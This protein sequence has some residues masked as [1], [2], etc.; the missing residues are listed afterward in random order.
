MNSKK[1]NK[2]TEEQVYLAFYDYSE[3]GGVLDYQYF[4]DIFLPKYLKITS[5]K[6]EEVYK[7]FMNKNKKLFNS[8]KNKCVKTLDTSAKQNA[9]TYIKEFGKDNKDKIIINI[10]KKNKDEEKDKE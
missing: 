1:S 3:N 10:L 6:D 7:S 4:I 2:I 5:L 8:I 9:I